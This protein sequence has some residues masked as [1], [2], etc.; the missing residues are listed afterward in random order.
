MIDELRTLTERLHFDL[1]LDKTLTEAH[2]DDIELITGVKSMTM[3]EGDTYHVTYDVWLSYFG[4]VEVRLRALNR[5]LTEP[6]SVK[7]VSLEELTRGESLFVGIIQQIE[8][9]KAKLQ[10]KPQ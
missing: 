4:A 2:A 9:L 6:E 10:A 3:L 8:A 1:R 5:L 7:Q